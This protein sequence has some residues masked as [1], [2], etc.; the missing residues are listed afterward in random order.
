M[1]KH[2]ITFLLHSFLIIAGMGSCSDEPEYPDDNESSWID[3]ESSSNEKEETP[4][5]DIPKLIKEH[6]TVSATYS[7]YVWHFHIE[8]T[9]HDVLPGKK[10]QFGIGHGDVN[11]TTSVSVEDQAYKYSSSMKNDVKIMD[12]EN[13]FWFYYIFGQEETKETKKAWTDCEIYYAAYLK[14]KN[15]NSKDLT[16]DEKKLMSDLPSYFR[17]YEKAAD[18]YY[19]PTIQVL[20][21]SHFYKIATYKR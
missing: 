11:G 20:I 19:K 18:N 7:E 3:N 17:E 5:V 13:P 9:L 12:F 21:D 10:I 6:V 4:T 14:L 15:K 1:R 2:L 8:S 16:E